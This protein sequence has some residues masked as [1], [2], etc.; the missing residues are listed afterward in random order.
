[1][2]CEVYLFDQ[3]I[4]AWEN[5][6]KKQGEQYIGNKDQNGDYAKKWHILFIF[7]VWMHQINPKATERYIKVQNQI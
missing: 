5:K 7:G 4:S 3:F 1:M 6:Q 2:N